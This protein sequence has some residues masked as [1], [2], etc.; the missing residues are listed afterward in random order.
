MR[1]VGHL[2]ELHHYSFVLY[3]SFFQS[4]FHTVDLKLSGDQNMTFPLNPCRYLR[5]VTHHMEQLK[6]FGEVPKKLTTQIKRSFVALR[7]FAQG[8]A[9]GRDVVKNVLKVREILLAFGLSVVINND[10][11]DY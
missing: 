5:C 8:L 3:I 10:K 11:P 7:T 4:S 9:T 1:S 6:P 2:L